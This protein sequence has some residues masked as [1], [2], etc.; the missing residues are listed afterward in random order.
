MS[1]RG[2]VIVAFEVHPANMSERRLEHG[3]RVDLQAPCRVFAHVAHALELPAE[4]GR[5][6]AALLPSETAVR[7]V[8]PHAPEASDS[9]G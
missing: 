2:P 7:H 6:G 5:A 9:A 3:G 8:L 4:Q 1:C